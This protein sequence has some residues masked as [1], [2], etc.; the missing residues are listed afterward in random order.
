MSD[1]LASG[2]F[3]DGYLAEAEEHL[4]I[5]R[6]SLVAVDEAHKRGQASPAPIRQLFRS[7]HTIKGLSAMV[8]A[9]PIVDI[10]HEMETLLRAADQLG[11]SLAPRAV[12]AISRGLEA[13]EER[14]GSLG[15][16]EP[17]PPAP[18]S[19][20]DELGSLQV[21]APEPRSTV[22]LTLEPVMLAKLSAGE[23]AQ[24]VQGIHDGRRALR[25]DF[26]PSPERALEG[27]TITRVRERMAALAEIVKV[28]PFTLPASAA[29]GGKVAFALL[30]LTRGGDAEVAEVAGASLAAVQVVALS[31]VEAGGMPAALLAGEPP[32]S[33][34]P[35]E[36][37]APGRERNFVRVEVS[38]LDD[39]LERLAAL[40]V[41]RSRLERAC[42][43]VSQGG[44]TR[45][46]T[47]MLGEHGRQLRDLRAAIMRARMVAMAE[48]LDRAPL[49]VRGLAR[50]A[51]KAV[52]L[53]IDVGQSEVDKSVADR[54]FPAIVHL[55]RNAVDH[56]IEPA[57]ERRRKGK[58]EEGQLSVRCWEQAGSR[59]ALEVRDDGR[60]IDRSRVAERAR[61]PVPSDDAELLELIVR[62][63]L[64]T[65]EQATHLSGRGLGMDIVKRLI[66]DELGGKLQL[67]TSLDRGTCFTLTVPLS[68][69][70]LE[71]F[72]FLCAERTFVVPV[73]AVETLAGIEPA[74][75]TQAPH[76]TKRGTVARML[77]HRGVSV[78][79]FSLGAMLGLSPVGSSNP[80]AILVRREAELFAFEVDRMLGQQE[81]VVRPLTDPLVAVEGV[82][83]ST[84]LGDG[85]PTL[86]LDPLLLMM[87][88]Q[89]AR[90]L[91]HE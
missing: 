28:L 43:A 76:P 44:S 89:N 74:Q 52:Q 88:Q 36:V 2:E 14:N 53:S 12:D 34:P 23:R 29:G 51:N 46:L 22:S 31:G 80:K 91:R 90:S 78:P 24:L 17:L 58:P 45:E 40:V 83:G 20:I 72:S 7:V 9:E 19:L 73:S 69:T 79:L 37:T 8:G 3:I 77:Q 16:R 5:A 30:V 25:V 42:A 71:A 50:S 10:A 86:V 27:F 75:V 55:L 26:V 54:L 1:P 48:V 81:I 68:V 64:S 84:D 57:E 59:L 32:L 70:V 38:R 41:S 67:S 85:R 4:S 35:A 60:G 6:A 15:R 62:P 82:T 21:Q 33:A 65:R 56:A 49:L 39:A 61:A 63:G 18:R 66:V 47:G 13:I 11:G 87:G